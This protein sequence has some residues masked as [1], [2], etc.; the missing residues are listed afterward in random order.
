MKRPAGWSFSICT[1]WSERV[2]LDV[3][4]KF[5]FHEDDEKVYW[6]VVQENVHAVMDT[7]IICKKRIRCSSTM[8]S[9]SAENPEIS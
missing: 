8:R 2:W 7:M 6:H 4:T 3:R 1:G 5:T 9:D